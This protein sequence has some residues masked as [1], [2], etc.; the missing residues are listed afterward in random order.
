MIAEVN[1]LEVLVGWSGELGST[2]SV[3]IKVESETN[4]RIYTVFSSL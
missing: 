1:P 2:H 3:S 4:E